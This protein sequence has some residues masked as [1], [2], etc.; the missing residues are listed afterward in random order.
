MWKIINL[1]VKI[2]KDFYSCMEGF[3]PW[4]WCQLYEDWTWKKMCVCE[5]WDTMFFQRPI[6]TWKP[7]MVQENNLQMCFKYATHSPLHWRNTHFFCVDVT[8]TT[9]W[10]QILYQRMEFLVWFE[11]YRDDGRHMVNTD[12]KPSCEPH[13]VCFVTTHNSIFVFLNYKILSFT[14]YP[15]YKSQFTPPAPQLDTFWIEEKS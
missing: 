14:I 4:Y 13:L 7:N 15:Y 5:K 12:N 2:M 10:L 1:F 11:R 9:S 8:T 3:F 6:K